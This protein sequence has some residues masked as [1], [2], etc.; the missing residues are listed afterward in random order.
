MKKLLTI[1]CVCTALLSSCSG[2]VKD[3]RLTSFDIISV[4][5]RGL[6]ELYAMVELGIHNPMVAFTLE[7]ARGVIK[8][9]GQPCIVLS[10]DQLLVDGNK[11]KVYVLPVKGRFDETF[12]PWQL[13]SLLKDK[14]FS[15]FTVDVSAKVSLRSG[16]GK[17][18][19]IN[20]MPL[21]KLLRH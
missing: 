19:V 10:A 1:L 7:D 13:L 6:N 12:N 8:M 4:T 18:I 16:I 9:E 11:D 14:D 3:I 17:D 15:R 20:D 2:G 21:D 5:P